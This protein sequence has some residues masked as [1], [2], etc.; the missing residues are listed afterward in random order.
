MAEKDN[1]PKSDKKANAAAGSAERSERKK[2]PGRQTGKSKEKERIAALEAELAESKD[3]LLRAKA[4]LD[5]YRKRASREIVETRNAAKANALASILSV[6]DHFR[7]AMDAAEKSDDMAVLKQGM[8]MIARE[9]DKAMEDAGVQVLDA[10]GSKFDPNL[11]EAVGK[12]NSDEEEGTVIEQWRCGYKLGERL[13]RPASVV[14]SDGPAA[15]PE[16]EGGEDDG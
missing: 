14:V 10:L 1:N 16:S 5:N 12:K 8:V 11:H 13:L 2:R 7:M 6:Y 4:E 3:A 9:F 15:G